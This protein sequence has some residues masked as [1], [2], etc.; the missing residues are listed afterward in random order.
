MP[1]RSFLQYVVITAKGLAMGAADVV[2]GVSG[3]TIAFIAGIYEELIETIHKLDLGFFRIWKKDGFKT[4]WT[5]YNLSFLVALF[6]GVFISIISLA[7]AITWL[8]AE[9][10][11]LV[12]SVLFWTCCGQYTLHWQANKNMEYKSYS[13]FGS[14]CWNCLCDHVGKTN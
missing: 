1:S 11:I 8:L 4:A 9:H 7:K 12:W 5:A 6:S 3:G 14:S 13:R 10:P 2:P